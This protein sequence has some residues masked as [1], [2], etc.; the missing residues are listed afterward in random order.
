M[1]SLFRREEIPRED[2]QQTRPV[3]P[4]R[5][6]KECDFWNNTPRRLEKRTVDPLKRVACRES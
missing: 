2:E 6:Q 1:R 3:L 4:A 5:A